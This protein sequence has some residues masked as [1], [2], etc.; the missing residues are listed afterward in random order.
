[1]QETCVTCGNNLVFNMN[2]KIFCKTCNGN[3]H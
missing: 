2:N 1:M 3:F